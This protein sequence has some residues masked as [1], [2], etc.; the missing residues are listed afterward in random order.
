MDLLN[1]AALQAAGTAVADRLQADTQQVLLTANQDLA[2]AL[3]PVL[4]EI[5]AFRLELAAWRI[6]FSGTSLKIGDSKEG[7]GK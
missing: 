1:S 7:E 2:S 3:V 6:M 5:K 4:A